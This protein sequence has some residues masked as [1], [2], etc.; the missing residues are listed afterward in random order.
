MRRERLVSVV[1][2]GGAGKTRLAL[3]AARLLLD[4]LPGGAFLVSLAP[5]T[6]PDAMLDAVVRALDLTGTDNAPVAQVA[7][8]VRD[9]P[10]LLVLDNF[11]QLLPAAP[12]VSQLVAA[13]PE[14][15]VLVTTQAA[16]R[17]SGEVVIGLDGLELG[18]AADLFVALA[19]GTAQHPPAATDDH[20]AIAEICRRVGCLPLAVELAAARARLLAPRQLLARLEVSSDI[21]RGVARDAPERQRSL[22]ATFEWTYGLLAPSERLLFRRLGVFAGPAGID[23]IEAVCAMP[24]GD[25]PVLVLDALEGLLEFSLVRRDERTEPSRRLTMPQAL[26]DFARAEWRS[27]ARRR[28]SGA[29]TRVCPG[30][31]RQGTGLVHGDP[32]ERA[33]VSMLQA[34]IRPV[35]RVGLATIPSSTEAGLRAGARP[36]PPRACRGGA[37]SRHAGMRHV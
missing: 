20:D 12:L 34:E 26:R 14:L 2:A 16:L 25:K 35:L 5:V 10:T 4:D 11:E 19:R 1:G 23:A 15:R 30:R 24:D 3:A 21:L 31:G 37:R 9:R 7:E 18:A 13:A 27:W 28:R 29:V 36:D 22:R 8:W 17:V 32:A 6:D 33:S